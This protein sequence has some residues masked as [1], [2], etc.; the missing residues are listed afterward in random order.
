L[1]FSVVTAVSCRIDEK[2]VI[3]SFDIRMQLETHKLSCLQA[4][5]S[6]R[7]LP[8]SLDSGMPAAR[9]S[10]CHCLMIAAKQQ[11][12]SVTG[13]VHFKCTVSCT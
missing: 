7:S 6:V 3:G 4:L 13:I 2:D 5:A 1:L 9:Q 12:L 10:C 8:P 11:G